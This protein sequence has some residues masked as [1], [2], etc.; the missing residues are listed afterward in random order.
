MVFNYFCGTGKDDIFGENPCIYSSVGRSNCR[1]RALTYCDLHRVHRDD[2]LD[3]LDM[4]PEFRSTFVNNLE[5]TYNMRDVSLTVMSLVS[6]PHYNVYLLPYII[7]PYV[8]TNFRP[9]LRLREINKNK[10]E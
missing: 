2:L 8:T 10:F 5:I 4:Y 7:S 3:V 6:E 9:R 1:V